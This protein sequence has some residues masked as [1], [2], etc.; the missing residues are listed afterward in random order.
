MRFF[1]Y[2]FFIQNVACSF[3]YVIHDTEDDY[4]R[5][6]SQN[7]H[8]CSGYSAKIAELQDD[9]CSS[10]YSIRNHRPRN[11][12]WYIW[13]LIGIGVNK[14]SLTV[15][16]CG[17]ENGH[18]VAWVT[19][20]KNGTVTFLNQEGATSSCILD[21]GLKIPSKCSMSNKLPSHFATLASTGAQYSNP[22]TNSISVSET[23]SVYHYPSPTS[24]LT[25]SIS[26][27][28][29]SSPGCKPP[30]PTIQ[31]KHPL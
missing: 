30:K 16:I 23:F 7:N 26:Q 5:L 1:N 14:T 11:C 17:T 19:V 10:E 31:V 12:C 18:D 6:W 13:D 21:N 8:G 2:C 22:A 9:D 4:C 29:T 3:L 27:T 28:A 15:G 24:E 20:N 25:H